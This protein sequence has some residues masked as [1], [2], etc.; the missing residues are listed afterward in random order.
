MILRKR[1]AWIVAAGCFAFLLTWVKA[2]EVLNEPVHSSQA[3]RP[4]AD[5]GIVLTGGIGRIREGFE[6]LQQGRV[7][8]L[9]VSGVHG[10]VQLEDIFPYLPYYPEVKTDNI[11]LDKRSLTTYGNAR[12][13]LNIAESFKCRDI[14]LITSQF[15]MPRAFSIFRSVFPDSTPIKKFTIANSKNESGL[16]DLGLEVLKSYSYYIFR[17]VDI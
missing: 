14:V 13:S 6:L 9:I 17:L 10:D 16:F 1:R 8:K 12:F 2:N 3:E 15:H 7:T 4:S 11:T 5:C